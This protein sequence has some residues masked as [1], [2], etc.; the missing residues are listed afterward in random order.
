[1]ARTVT[2]TLDAKVSGLVNGIK[3]ASKATQ[4]Y[5][6]DLEKWRKKNEDHL[7]TIGDS[8]GKA[9]IA[10]AAGLA[11]VAKSATDWESAWAGVT[12]TVDGTPAQLAEVEGG[13]RDLAKTLPSTHTEIAAVAEAAGQLGV[14]RDDVVGFT[15]TMID[16]GETTNLTADE[17][18]TNIAQISNV[19][20]TMDRE[21]SVGVE[22]FGAALV[23]LGNDG[24]S[25]EAEILNMA[26]RIAGAG[27]TLGASEAD[28]LALSNTLASMGIRAELGGGVATRV[29]LKMRTAVDE[30][31]ESTAAFAKIAGTSADEFASKFS[32]APMEALSL[33]AKGI[34]RTNDAGGN[35]TAT[36]KD[37]GIKG[38][39][40][41]QVML[42]LASSGDLLTESLEL[43]SKAWE[44][45][46]ALLDEASKRY[47]TTESKVRIAWNN[48]SDAAIEAGAVL[49]PIISEMAESI[50]GLASWFGDLPPAAQGFITVLGTV[51]AVAGL[52]VGGVITF[53]RKIGE[54]REAFDGIITTGGRSDKAIR[55]VGK[56]LGAITVVGAGL[57]IGKQTIEAINDA[58]RAGKPGLEEYFNLIATGTG[59][60]IAKTLDFAGDRG[61]AN[62]KALERYAK[63]V[64]AITT[65]S[66]AAKR[67]LEQVGDLNW[68]EKYLMAGAGGM[69]EQVEDALQLE[70]LGK[71]LARTFEMGEIEIATGSLSDFASQMDLTD[72]EIAKL[73]NGVPDLKS[74]LMGLATENGI[75]IDP[76]NELGLVD[77]ALG[78]IKLS[79]PDTGDAI[80][81]VGENLEDAAA[82]AEDAAEKIDNFYESLVNAGAVVLS[83]R[84][85]MRRLEASFD[86]AADSFT[87]N[88]KTLDGS[89]EK[90]RANQEALDGI[91]D[92]SHRAMEAQRE[93]GA[94]TAELGKTL[95][96]GREE[97]VKFA[98]KMGM[99][100][101][102]ASALAD[103]LNLIPGA[104]YIQFDSNTG[105]LEENL[106]TIHELVQSTPDKT[107]QIDENS[108]QVIS[109]LENLGYIV[110]E[111][112]DGRIEVSETG[113][114]EA[115]DKI[116]K[117]AGKKRTA[118]I[119]AE[120]ITGAA[121]N[122]LD[123]LSRTRTASIVATVVGGPVGAM[124]GAGIN[125]GGY[126]G[127]MVGQLINGR[128][129]GGLV[130]GK[131]PLNSQG[132]NVLATVGGKPF[133]LRS[134]EMVVN[135]EATRENYGLL[136]AINDGET[137]RFPGFMDGGSL[138]IPPSREVVSHGQQM[139]PNIINIP[140]TVQGAGD[141]DRAVQTLKDQLTTA[142]A[143]AGVR[144][145][146]IGNA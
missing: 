19:M 89:T 48:I 94:S 106:T 123:A 101:K 67:A 81:G 33:V 83:E 18:A 127:G 43:G 125:A 59:E 68:F 77:L 52:G 21:G 86:S 24:A 49:L 108:P 111:L 5:S 63:K 71:A 105:S 144:I 97:F 30:G 26:Q 79:A 8:S 66:A 117:E 122:E 36:M 146:R 32:S 39:E 137:F 98:E 11:L 143:G 28:V 87:K 130:P 99:S 92:A 35:L 50:A 25:T 4:D 129:G 104:V 141:A 135:E 73:I 128:A 6:R 23:A 47:E 70:E 41:M 45:N 126:T 53:S 34:A 64:G 61:A 7:D 93:N 51:G 22:R 44:D 139:Q 40:E 69:G 74:A 131:I 42:A 15:K 3:T 75:Q 124:L 140:I 118:K 116:D 55:G 133:G 82:S 88:G 113:T 80:S 76:N 37:M 58:V 27:A 78:R 134:G 85:A 17:A 107:I 110:T 1:M 9:G 60:D 13:L 46:T 91:A 138:M 142:L 102:E 10:A 16:L 14:A 95:Q 20:G 29:L 65:E 103:E 109:A 112:P 121:K 120:A 72:Q 56:A 114:D 12:K 57:I 84:D 2:L 132:D 90:G 115:G 54:L 38:T 136:K 62:E 100:T 145:G 119:N 96:S 31:G